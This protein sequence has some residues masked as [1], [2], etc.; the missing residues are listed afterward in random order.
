MTHFTLVDM[1]SVLRVHCNL[2]IRQKLLE[3]D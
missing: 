3:I 2:A 1:L